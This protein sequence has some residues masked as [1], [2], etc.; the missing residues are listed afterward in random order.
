MRPFFRQVS[1]SIR[2]L[3]FGVFVLSALA[4]VVLWIHALWKWLDWPGLV[5][6]VVSAPLAV[7]LP[8]IRWLVDGV[9]PVTTFALWAVGVAGLALSLGWGLIESRTRPSEPPPAGPC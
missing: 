6:G 4:M 2:M 9:F 3:S 1:N 5:L 8:F 7:V